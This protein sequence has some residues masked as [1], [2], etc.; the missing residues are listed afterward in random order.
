MS[1]SSFS[2]NNT[3]GVTTGAAGWPPW[4]ARPPRPA[5]T[6]APRARAGRTRAQSCGPHHWGPSRERGAARGVEKTEE[7][8]WN[9]WRRLI[10]EEDS[11]WSRGGNHRLTEIWRSDRRTRH[12]QTNPSDSADDARIGS[13]CSPKL[14]LEFDPL[15]TSASNSASWK[16]NMGKPFRALERARQGEAEHVYISRVQTRWKFS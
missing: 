14:S 7:L 11:H 3:R 2:G 6:A 15:R 12:A 16:F 8:G 1:C 5:A 10:R 13:N 4:A 9:P